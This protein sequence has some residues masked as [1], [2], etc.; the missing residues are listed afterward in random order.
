[1]C[2]NR[3]SDKEKM[4]NVQMGI[5]LTLS[6]VSLDLI[7]SNYYHFLMLSVYNKMKFLWFFYKFVKKNHSITKKLSYFLQVREQ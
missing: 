6:I 5:H 1:M 4:P 3:C 2:Q 7:L